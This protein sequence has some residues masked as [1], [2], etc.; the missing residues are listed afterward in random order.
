MSIADET[1]EARLTY[2]LRLAGGAVPQ[3]IIVKDQT[4]KRAALAF[5]EGKA[6]AETLQIE[7]QAEYE[8]RRR[9]RR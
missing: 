3:V 2:A 5:L 4:E 9:Q 8:A 1:L 6:G 7:T